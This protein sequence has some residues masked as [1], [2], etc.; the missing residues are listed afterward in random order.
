MKNKALW[1]S[2]FILGSRIFSQE[3]VVADVA[4]TKPVKPWHVDGQFLFNLGNTGL[5]NWS[6]GGASTVSANL[7]VI[8]KF[9]YEIPNF[10]WDNRFNLGYGGLYNYKPQ[11]AYPYRKSDDVLEYNT[12]LDYVFAPPHWSWTVFGSNSRTQMDKGYDYS[13][14][15]GTTIRTYLSNLLSPGYN[16]TY[17]GITYRHEGK[18]HKVKFTMAPVAI[19]QT[20]VLSKTLSKQGAFGI[21]TN[22]NWRGEMGWMLLLNGNFQLAKNIDFE[23]Q[24]QVFGRYEKL[25]GIDAYWVNTLNLKVNNYLTA[26]IGTYTIYDYYAEF[27][28]DDG[29]KGKAIQFKYMVNVGLSIKISNKPKEKE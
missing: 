17:T 25:V 15:N 10:V 6:G 8:L 22:K 13:Q 5:Y 7:G 28:R 12:S 2:A 3:D 11:I 26:N 19:K 27:L 24:L 23:T 14:D 18:R 29:T 16:Y 1:L 21:D 20:I 4:N 9:S